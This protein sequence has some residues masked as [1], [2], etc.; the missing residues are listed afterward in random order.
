MSFDSTLKANLSVGPPIDMQVHVEN[1]LDL[2]IFRRFEPDDFYFGAISKS[3]GEA[4][5]LAFDSLPD[6]MLE[7]EG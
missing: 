7:E 3:W 6:V 1:T 2:G 5:N 4:L